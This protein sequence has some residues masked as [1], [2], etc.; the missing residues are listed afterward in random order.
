MKNRKERYHIRN[1]RKAFAHAR[2]AGPVSVRIVNGMT[3]E[4]IRYMEFKRFPFRRVT[5]YAYPH[6]GFTLDG[7]DRMIFS[8]IRFESV[9]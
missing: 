3:G 1:A 9:L 6:R 7:P 8:T 2:K 4:T 5:A